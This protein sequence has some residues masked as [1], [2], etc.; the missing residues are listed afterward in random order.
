MKSEVRHLAKLPL[1]QLLLW[2]KF[3]LGRWGVG[4]EGGVERGGMLSR[5]DDV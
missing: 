5:R 3:F 4:E 2:P 1:P